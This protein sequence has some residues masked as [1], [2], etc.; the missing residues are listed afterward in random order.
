MPGAGRERLRTIPCGVDLVEL[1]PEGVR[2]HR[3]AALAERWN[4]GAE[5]R[6]LLLPAP[7]AEGYGQHLLLEAVA[8]LN[9][10]DLLV[11]LLG[12]EQ[13]GSGYLRTLQQTMSR[14]DIAE[15]VRFAADCPD[16]PAAMQMADLVVLPAIQPLPTA[17]AVIAAQAMGKPV[18]VSNVGALPEL[19]M[20]AMTG[21]LVPSGDVGE[22][23]WAIERALSLDPEVR[24]RLAERARSFVRAEF[25]LEQTAARTLSVYQE[26]LGRKVGG[27]LSRRSVE[28]VGPAAD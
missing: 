20:P 25:D 1:D 3:V 6:I 7:L 10:H 12:P 24:Q 4:L 14:L 21:W 17:R 9:R 8:R 26:L 11:L 16:M 23:A 13:A 18:V 19:V 2:G 5:S 15:H 28:A 22:L 27:S